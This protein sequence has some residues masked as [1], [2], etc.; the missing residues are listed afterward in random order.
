MTD[1][2]GRS[3]NFTWTSGQITKM[4]SAVSGRS[5]NLTWSTPTGAQAAHVATV[6]TDPVTPGDSSTVQT[7]TYGYS[8]D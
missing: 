7:W 6:V 8:G 2:N 4:T 5:L 3:V 1:A